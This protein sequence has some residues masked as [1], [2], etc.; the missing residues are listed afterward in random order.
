MKRKFFFILALFFFTSIFFVFQNRD[1]TIKIGFAGGLSGQW[2]QISIDARNGFLV[3][4]EEINSNGGVNGKKL[5]PYFYNDQSN[6]ETGI[7]LGEKFEKDNVN[8][9]VGFSISQLRRAVVEI[10]RNQ[11]ILFISPTM[12]TN[13]LS[14][15][16][17]YFF[18]VIPENTIQAKML[19][20]YLQKMDLQKLIVV[21]NTNN[22]EFS[23]TLMTHLKHMSRAFNVEVVKTIG[24]DT[25]DL[26]AVDFA[27]EIKSVE[28][29]SVFFVTNSMDTANLAQILKINDID[30]HLCSSTWAKT[31]DL[32]ENGGKAIEDMV[33]LGYFDMN[34][35]QKSYVD[36]KERIQSKFGT[37][38]SYAHILGY[39]SVK[40]LEEAILHSN[41]VEPS[42]IKKAIIEIEKYTGVLDDFTIDYYGDNRR[43]PIIFRIKNGEY[44]NI[45]HIL[46]N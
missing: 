30:L 29:D 36:F 4:V 17:D 44:E 16:D 10:M 18:R 32:I 39:E 19:L 33:I 11:E 13:N 7:A 12:T 46:S 34:S 28:S 35:H 21:Y 27:K 40:V 26:T 20:D 43:T 22:Y 5:E 42:E 31:S 9:V 1:Q 41:S 15:M 45:S 25:T 8:L 2:S 24:I 3:A 14:E 6:V 38:T 23:Y 37:S